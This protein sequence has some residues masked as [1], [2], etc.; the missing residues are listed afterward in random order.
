M[1]KRMVGV[2]LILGGA[3]FAAVVIGVDLIGAGNMDGIGPAQR[4]AMGAAVGIIL[5]GIT[6]VP[7]GDRPA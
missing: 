6:L 5:V 1:T 4:F 7:L 2:A 3:V